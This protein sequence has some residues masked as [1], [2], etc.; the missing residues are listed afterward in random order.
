MSRRLLPT[1]AA[2]LA[3]TLAVSAAQAADLPKRISW[4]AYGTTSS[5]YAN[6]VAIGNVLKKHYDSEVR[7]VPG[8]NDVSR[9]IP[10]EKGKVDLCACGMA[11][12][13]AQEGVFDFGKKR[14]GP[15]RLYNLFNNAKGKNGTTLALA[16][17][18]GV[19][20]LAD[21]RG[22]RM[23]WVRG[24][25]ALNVNLEGFLAFG[26]L[27]WDDVKKVE[28]PGWKQ[29]VDGVINGQAD[30]VI[31]STVSPHLQRLAASPRG[32]IHPSTPHADKEGWARAKSAAPWWLP[33]LVSVGINLES[34]T[35]KQGMVP[36]EGI[37]FPYPAYVTYGDRSDDFAYALTK[38]VVSNH[39]AIT[40]ALKNADGYGI[41]RQVFDWALPY[42]P[43]SIKYYKEIGAWGDKEAAH[44]AALLKRQD[45]LAAAWKEAVAMNLDGEAHQNKWREMRGAALEAAGMVAPFK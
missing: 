13:L 29:A 36:F 41:D 35:Q 3:A 2:A 8:K 39:E 34:N 45:V 7:L 26:G 28:F 16:N 17:D 5:G 15:Q 27:T 43:G 19:K 1:F 37:G 40:A 14:W 30:A 6:G 24:A 20:S 42:H 33:R 23:A 32:S 44:N 31:V 22:K 10:V 4:T 21:L 12:I 18:V 38:A 25:P 9:M 11:A